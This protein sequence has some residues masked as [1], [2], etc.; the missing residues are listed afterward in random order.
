[1][2]KA[3]GFILVAVAL[4]G[5]LSAQ[6]ADT[7]ASA[8]LK[9]IASL[10]VP[11]YM[12]RWYEVAKYPNRFQKE[13]VADTSA[14]YSLNP[15]GTVQVINRC[16]QK[17]G[18]FEKAIGQARQVGDLGSPKLK[19]RFAPAWLSFLP[20]VWGD[21]WVIDIDSNYQL[22]AVSEPKR[23]YLWV[24][25]RGPT[26]DEQSYRNLLGRLSSMGFDVTKLE[27]TRQGQ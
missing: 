18:A 8:Q 15:D 23:E 4:I 27:P 12:G 10:D 16:R 9:T 5:A 11:R 17:N 1:M 7:V 24:L 21:Y 22:V 2:R 26:V 3:F 13:C 14:T 6:A 25:S 20:F 19:V